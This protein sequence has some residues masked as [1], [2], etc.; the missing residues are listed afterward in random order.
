MISVLSLKKK[1]SRLSVAFESQNVRRVDRQLNV[2]G[3]LL[4]CLTEV[5]RFGT[6][7]S[8]N[9]FVGEMFVHL[10]KRFSDRFIELLRET[11][12][13]FRRSLVFSVLLGEVR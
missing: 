7:S 13:D 9:G 2:V 6:R 12:V 8:E 5:I 11:T 10:M 1:S 3:F 4:R